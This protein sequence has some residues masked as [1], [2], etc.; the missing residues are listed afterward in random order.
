MNPLITEISIVPVKP[1][2]GLVAFAS[3]VLNDSLYLGSVAIFTRPT[4]GYRLIYPSK[5]V[6]NRQ[7]NFFHPINREF[8][9]FIEKAVIC[10]FEE[11]MKSGETY[12]RHYGNNS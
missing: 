11:V 4:G 1:N 12:G 3:F 10:R 2:N 5:T 8:A 6:G 7:I 9:Q